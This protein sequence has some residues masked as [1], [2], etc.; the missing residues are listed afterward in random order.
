MSGKVRNN[1][2]II[3]HH[4]MNCKCSMSFVFSYHRKSQKALSTG[5]LFSVFFII[6]IKYRSCILVN[7]FNFVA[8]T[9][10]VCGLD[11]E[12]RKTTMTKCMLLSNVNEVISHFIFCVSKVVVTYAINRGGLCVV[13]NWIGDVCEFGW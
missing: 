6:L 9:T 5:S 12:I 4:P 7:V 11:L 13:Y 8:L 3:F 1:F 2:K 10:H